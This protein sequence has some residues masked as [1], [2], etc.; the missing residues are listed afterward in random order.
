[1]SHFT[2]LVIGNEDI[3]AAL[4]PYWE[5]DLP[6]DK[7]KEDY[8][9]VFNV[10][11]SSPEELREEAEKIL[12]SLEDDRDENEEKD[13]E[14]VELRNLYEGY[15]QNLE[16]NKIVEDYN[17]Y[18]Q[19][20]E[21][22]NE[23]GYWTNPNAKWDWYTIGGR[24]HKKLKLKPGKKGFVGKPS[25]LMDMSDFPQTEDYADQAYYG[26]IDWDE[27]QKMTPEEEAKCRRF[28]EIATEEKPAITEE[29]KE[30]WIEY[31][32]EYYFK[33]YGTVENY[34][35]E[36][37]LFYTFAVITPDGA[38]HEKGEMGWWGIHNATPEDENTW[39]TNYYDNFLKN[40]TDDTLITMVDCH[41]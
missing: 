28:W 30:W 11:I 37:K 7:L 27:M 18:E 3:D 23:Y 4:D 22:P 5:L 21:D 36:R 16:W 17:G 41:I 12:L 26:D 32:P 2:V 38:W 9:A 1:M 6:K 14:T 10:R 31:K 25:L 35:K 8:R 33:R 24:W 15:K 34:I 40:L 19:N 39:S 13:P 29:E 20:P